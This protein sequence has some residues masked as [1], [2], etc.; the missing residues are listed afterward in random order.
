MHIQPLLLYV[1]WDH[2][3]CH[4]NHVQHLKYI[5]TAQHT[6][7]RYKRTPLT[8][9][10]SICSFHEGCI[11]PI[12]QKP[13]EVTHGYQMLPEID[14]LNVLMFWSIE[15]KHRRTDRDIGFQITY[16]YSHRI[17]LVPNGETGFHR[18]LGR[19]IQF[20]LYWR[21]FRVWRLWCQAYHF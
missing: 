3:Y 18:Q 10:H 21:K 13:W 12:L 4:L 19:R 5:R 2:L 16:W 9:L 6:L 1:W 7:L 15:S 17:R 11:A 8:A 20:Q 14:H